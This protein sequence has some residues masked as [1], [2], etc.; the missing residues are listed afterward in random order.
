[1]KSPATATTVTVR[2]PMKFVIRGGRKTIISERLAAP[3]QPRIDNALLKAP[4][5]AHR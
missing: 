2:V 3:P 4:A 5:R 1:M